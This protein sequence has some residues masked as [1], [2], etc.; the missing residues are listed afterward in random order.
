MHSKQQSIEPGHD[1]EQGRGGVAFA[2]VTV[3]GRPDRRWGEVPVAVAVLAD[4]AVA[5]SISE[6][7]EW[8]AGR[9][10]GYKRPAD[11]RVVDALPRTALGK[12]RKHLLSDL[13]AED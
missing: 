9:L 13:V 11:L 2:E 8:C 12:V 5:P 6:L 1:T 3:V 10:A 7:R 4:G